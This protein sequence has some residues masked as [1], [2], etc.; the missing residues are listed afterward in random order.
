[1]LSYVA[2]PT[3]RLF[4]AL[5]L[6]IVLISAV[7][8]AVISVKQAGGT[9]SPVTRRN[10]VAAWNAA[11]CG[12]EIQIEAGSI[13]RTGAEVTQIVVTA[14]G[15][16]TITFPYAHDFI[17]GDYLRMFGVTGAGAGLNN[18]FPIT[19]ISSPTSVVA[20]VSGLAPS[21]TYI[22]SG[23]TV[24]NGWFLF[25]YNAAK[26]D[27]PA[28]NEITFTTTKKDWLPD[29]DMRITP[30]YKSL[31]P[32]IQ[33]LGDHSNTPLVQ[34]ADR[35]KGLKFV[36]IGFQKVGLNV[37][38]LYRLID[39]TISD[40]IPDQNTIVQRITFDRNL[41]YNDYLLGNTWKQVLS[42]RANDVNFS[43]NFV[44]NH[45]GLQSDG[46]TY[47][48]ASINSFGPFKLRNNYTCCAMSIPFL[49]GGSETTF[50]TGNPI[51]KDILIEHNHFY[52]S[53]KHYPA[54][55]T[56]VGDNYRGI[57]KNCGELKTGI[58]A[59]FRWNMCEN[60]FSGGGSQWYGFVYSARANSYGGSGTCSLDATK[61]VLT[62]PQQWYGNFKP[63]HVYGLTTG[64][65]S[66]TDK[67]QWRTIV[68]A[69]NANKV[70]TVD[71]PFDRAQGLTN[72]S[73]AWV[74]TPWWKISNVTAYG[75]YFRNVA[76]SFQILGADIYY[77]DTTTRDIVMKNNL[78]VYDTPYMKA[79]ST[80]FVYSLLFITSSGKNIHY[81]NNTSYN[82]DTFKPNIDY[83]RTIW[84]ETQ[85]NYY[86]P[87]D[88]LHIANNLHPYS[89]W[90]GSSGLY[91]VLVDQG[92]ITNSSVHNNTITPT[93]PYVVPCPPQDC[94]GNITEGAYAPQFKNPKGNDY[95]LV[96]GSNYTNAGIDGA[97]MGV[98]IEE[99]AIIRE[100]EIKPSA[101][102]LLFSWRVPTFMKSMGCQLEVSPHSNL[103]TDLGA[104]TSVNA[105]RPDYFKR[106]DSDRSNK[107]AT[108]SDSMLHRWFQVGEATIETDDNGI[109]R[110][111]SLE[112]DTQYYYRLMCGGATERGSVRT[113]AA[114]ADS[115]N[116]SP[117][118][119]K[120]A[121]TAI[122]GTRIRARYGP[123]RNSLLTSAAVS[124]AS[125]CTVI[126]PATAGR[127]LIYYIDELDD[128][129]GV[130]SQA[131]TPVVLSI[132]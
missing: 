69:D 107:R 14:G 83:P 68:S 34:I 10:V 105:L 33:L 114:G 5:L 19:A 81:S 123:D 15:N 54:S 1:M 18:A 46:E 99:V 12:D 101:N 78:T 120:I 4:G 121:A 96:P 36:G 125:G 85:G 116:R 51:P 9:F 23:I 16:A 124:C 111:L 91:R 132:N 59:I 87:T 67:Y 74:L 61:T 119:V 28:G 112:P 43:N 7:N 39:V 11:S 53:L 118:E 106:A 71:Q 42:L 130:V 2:V 129:N 102:N 64:S 93:G 82:K 8:A 45:M 70:Y 113:L 55:P 57:V 13:A 110:N 17:T 26:N 48:F 75:N 84:L 73:Y 38:I 66:Y 22:N 29:P 127:Q 109:A 90:Y 63:G 76:S 25:E 6:S 60:S 77:P 56:Y 30:M 122:R 126:L 72:L 35:I 88:N 20:N 32:T 97:D 3:K 62:C 95:S 128:N 108:K 21:G 92:H 115:V 37:S 79:G 49:W 44:D 100:L 131:E 47:I 52:T 86:G 27:C 98:D 103:T 117:L 41:F 31:I 80:D 58:G 24:Y 40:N 94:S 50:T 65:A 104:Y 89:G